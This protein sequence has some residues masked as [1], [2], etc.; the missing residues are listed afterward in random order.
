[1]DDLAERSCP[2]PGDDDAAFDDEQIA[3]H[4]EALDEHRWT[5]ED[6]HHLRG[7]FPFDDFKSAMSFANTVGELAEAEWHH[8]DIHISWGEVG[9]EVFTHDLGGLWVADFILAAKIDRAYE[10]AE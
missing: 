1:M 10:A 6:G 3:R 5:V 2:T 4:L 8:P 9:I 7:T